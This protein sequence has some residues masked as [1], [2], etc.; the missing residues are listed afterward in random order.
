MGSRGFYA[1]FLAA[2]IL[3]RAADVGI[4]WYVIDSGLGYERNPVAAFLISRVGLEAGLALFFL[5]GVG[6]GAAL[7]WGVPRMLKCERCRTRLDRVLMRALGAE[8]IAE[9]LLAVALGLSLAPVFIN[10]FC[11][12]VATR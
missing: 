1:A 12:Y 3:G 7:A 6:V 11:L 10:A 5:L 8:R 9:I 2:W 4:T